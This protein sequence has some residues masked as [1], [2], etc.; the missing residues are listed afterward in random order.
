MKK[1]ILLLG[2][3]ILF[4]I[5]CQLL[6]NIFSKGYEIEYILKD[7]NNEYKIKEKY[8]KNVKGEIDNYLITINTDNNIYS[9]Q[10]YDKLNDKKNIEEIKY[11]KDDNVEC[12]LPLFQNQQIIFDI[13]CSY[14]NNLMYYHNM[15]KKDEKLLDFVESLN[16]IYDENKFIDNSFKET[17]EGLYTISEDNIV[18]DHYIA[19]TNYQ[20]LITINTKNKISNINIFE[21]DKYSREISTFVDNYYIVADYSK[22]YEFDKF[23]IVNLKNNS[24]Q[25]IKYN[26]KISFD[27]YIQGVVNKCVYIFDP[28]NKIQYEIDLEKLTINEIGDIDG[29]KYYENGSW[30]TV[31]INEAIEK[32]LTFNQDNY[33][34][35]L[36]DGTVVDRV[37]NNLSGYIYTYKKNEDKTYSMYISN[38]VTPKIKNY[39]F[40]I[41]NL[42]NI[43]YINDYVYFKDGNSIKYYN[44]KIGIK[45]LITSE[46]ILFNNDIKY[47][48]IN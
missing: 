1:M 24:I 33:R 7:K 13:T 28:D 29:I 19:L 25:T 42:D 47:N 48:V 32:E 22:N 2:I 44:E 45:N 10:I 16:D 5:S 43:I 9:Y 4:Y 21:V 15:K 30:S 38:I 46:E 31:G 35:K 40:D 41:D 3:M 20:G 17:K 39:L 18:E 36:D 8:T 23:Y 37:G 14:D 11:Y 26:Y 27:S 34:D 12:I 6:L